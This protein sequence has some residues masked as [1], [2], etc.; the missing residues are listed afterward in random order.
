MGKAL[1]RLLLHREQRGAAVSQENVC[2]LCGEE[3]PSS[4]GLS[5]HRCRV[6]TEF[7]RGRVESALSLIEEAQNRIAD[8]SAAISRVAGLSAECDEL[9]RLYDTVKDKWHWLNNRTAARELDMDSWWRRDRGVA[10]PK[11]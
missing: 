11:D 4:L 6:T 2:R 7:A 9:G 8:A 5:K 10:E 3:F 1:L